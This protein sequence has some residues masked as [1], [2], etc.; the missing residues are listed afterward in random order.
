LFVTANPVLEQP[1]GGVLWPAYAD[2][3]SRRRNVHNI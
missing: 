1:A 2:A 3:V